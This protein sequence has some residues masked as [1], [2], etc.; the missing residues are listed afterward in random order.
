M[1]SGAN[2]P[3]RAVVQMRTA[4]NKTIGSNPFA[5]RHKVDEAKEKE[6]VIKR[7]DWECS[8]EDLY[9]KKQGKD[10]H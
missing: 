4:C 1:I 5:S 7:E 10:V 3:D 6:L 9:K 8:Y 2:L